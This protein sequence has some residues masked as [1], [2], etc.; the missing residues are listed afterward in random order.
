MLPL[1]YEAITSKYRIHF[2]YQAT[3]TTGLPYPPSL[4]L[5]QSDPTLIPI[6]GMALALEAVCG[7]VH[8]PQCLVVG[9]GGV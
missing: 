2:S 7:R 3:C 4:T 6:P 1:Y 8:F 5:T 9:T